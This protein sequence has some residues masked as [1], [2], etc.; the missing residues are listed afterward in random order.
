MCTQVIPLPLVSP[1]TYSNAKKLLFNER[2]QREILLVMLTSVSHRRKPHKYHDGSEPRAH[3]C[4][5]FSRV[6]YIHL[7]SSRKCKVNVMIIFVS[8]S[9]ISSRYKDFFFFKL[10]VIRSSRF[11]G[12]QALFVEFPGFLCWSQLGL[13]LSKTK[14]YRRQS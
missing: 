10:V 6:Q 14:S 2:C 4:G 13:A 7:Y 3:S 8:N 5:Y 12:T 1:S 11:S 9:I